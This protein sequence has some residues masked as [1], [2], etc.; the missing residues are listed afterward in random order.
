MIDRF[1]FRLFISNLIDWVVF[2]YFKA[3][4][5]IGSSQLIIQIENWISKHLAPDYHQT[6]N[7]DFDPNI[8]FDLDRS[9]EV[10]KSFDLVRGTDTDL[11]AVPPNLASN[12]LALKYEHDVDKLYT[13]SFVEV[14]RD[15]GT[16]I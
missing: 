15:L 13:D 12:S 1:K 2:F 3:K 14:E 8:K 5:P 11:L 10:L 6:S 4:I 7:T 9:L 16:R